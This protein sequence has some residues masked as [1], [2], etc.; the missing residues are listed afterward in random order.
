MTKRGKPFER[1]KSPNPAGR[2]KGVRS[3]TTVALERI[4]EGDA[5]AIVR[6]LTAAALDGDAVALRL[7]LERLLPARK[8]RPVRFALP[9]IE[10][11]ADLPKATNALLQAVAAGDLTPSEASD[12]SRSVDAHIRAIEVSDL[13]VRLLRLEEARGGR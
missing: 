11:M 4:L 7:C 12:I 8:D 9:P 5:E 3:R 1:G 13:N 6:K 2:P 10:T